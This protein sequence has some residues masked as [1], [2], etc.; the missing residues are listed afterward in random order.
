VVSTAEE[1]YWDP[2][3]TELDTNPYDVWRRLRDEAPLYRNDAY[4]F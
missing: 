1:I 2:F 3:D 4:D